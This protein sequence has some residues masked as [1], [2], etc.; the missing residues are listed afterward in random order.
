MRCLQKKL[1]EVINKFLKP[2][3]EKRR[4]Y[5]GQEKLIKTI[6]ETGNEKTQREAKKTIK[7]AREAMHFDYKKLL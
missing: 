3:R 1:S 6:L 5:D 2:I 7:L 4:Y